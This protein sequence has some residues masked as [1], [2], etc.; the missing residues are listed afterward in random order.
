MG[1]GMTRRGLG[2][3]AT[4]ALLVLGACGGDDDGATA[5]TAAATTAADVASDTT[6]AEPG[7]DTTAADDSPT[8]TESGTDTTAANDTETTTAGETPVDGGTLTFVHQTDP[9]LLD[10]IAMTSVTEASG[11]SLW[12]NAFGG[13][14]IFQPDGTVEPFLAED[15]T[16]ADGGTTWVLK[17]RPGLQ[18]SDGTALDAEAVKFN[19]DRLADPANAAP[20]AANLAN[21]QSYVV[22]DPQTITITLK[23]VN[24]NFPNL[25][26]GSA[27]SYIGS[28]T[29]IA[30]LGQD[31]GNQ[32]V[33]AGPFV[34]Q[35]WIRSDHST[36]NKSPSFF[37]ADEVHLDSVVVRPVADETQK[38][39]A[40]TT[41]AADVVW[42]GQVSTV[43][44]LEAAGGTTDSFP[45]TGGIGIMFN[46]ARPPFDDPAVRTAF[47]QAMNRDGLTEA[48]TGKANELGSGF[49]SP[50]SQYFNPDAQY[51]A[52]DLDAAQAAIDAYTAANGPIELSMLHVA[53]APSV[54]NLVTVLQSQ[55]QELDG[56]SISLNPVDLAAQAG[57]WRSG[58]WDIT[59]NGSSSV[60]F[61]PGMYNLLHTG[62]SFNFSGYSNAAVDA[63]LDRARTTSDP[64][65]AKAAYDEVQQ[66]LTEDAY[67]P[68]FVFSNYRLVSSEK[69]HLE[70]FGDG[71]PRTDLTW[72]ED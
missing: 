43:E 62:G 69:V 24:T 1:I 5:D 29:A 30:A 64:D 28:P 57:V 14:L 19:W 12:F 45:L 35:E 26:A 3:L 72:I 10:P 38:M 39:N 27:L 63:A 22:T 70:S 54:Q 56:V 46:V 7:S 2:A 66:A 9:R 8:T 49:L 25:V 71:T 47:V 52:Y 17:L 15:L 18:F 44:A 11:L 4:A 32:P 34:L 37:A 20:Q 42:T 61:D 53:G 50:E 31:F 13:L 21:V 41:G 16:S 6:A 68:P 33:G 40:F 51:P 23:T 65:E 36:W 48:Y 55:L 59:F 67:L 60:V 58:D